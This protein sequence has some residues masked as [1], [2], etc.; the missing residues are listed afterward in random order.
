MKRTLLIF[1]C[2]L[3]LGSLFAQAPTKKGKAVNIKDFFV[4]LPDEAFTETGFT[5]K[6]R[7]EM[8]KTIGQA[9]VG[10]NPY[11]Y[12]DVCDIRN[13]YMSTFFYS[14]EGYKYELCYWNLKDGRKL[15]AVNKDSGFSELDFYIYEGGKL[16][17][18]DS[19]APNTKDIRVED[20][21]DTS[22]LDQKEKKVLK[23]LFENRMVFR[24]CLPRQGKSIDMV[25][26]FIPFDMEY[27]GLLEDAGLEDKI[28]HKHVIFNWVNEKWVKESK[29]SERSK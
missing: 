24:I 28:R 8:L 3:Y 25:M 20:F 17:K 21:F 16:R 4:M 29:I 5:L 12:I 15:L 9:N 2:A 18:D 10:N 6:E 7:K 11:A 14:L 13:G 22:R 27:E 1:L 19:L 23:D 26:G